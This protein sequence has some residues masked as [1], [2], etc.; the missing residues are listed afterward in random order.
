MGTW[1]TIGLFAGLGVAL[2]VLFAGL[3]GRSRG[4]VVLA[5]VL[6]AAAGAAAGVFLSDWE[7]AAGGALG[8]LL[9]AGGAAQIVGG[10]LR[11]GGTRAGTALLFLLGAILLALLA[12]VPVVGYIEAVV[13]PALAARLRRRAAGRTYAGLRI[14]ARD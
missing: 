11:R 10:T 14:L 1:Y 5:I 12:L 13:V 4:G 7:E 3:L 6:G 2:G 8:G 9:G